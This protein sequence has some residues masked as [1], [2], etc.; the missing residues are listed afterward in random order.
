MLTLKKF[1]TLF[2]C[3]YHWLWTSKRQLGRCWKSF[4]IYT[5]VT[6][7]KPGQVRFQDFWAHTLA[8]IEKKLAVSLIH[9]LLQL[10][11]SWVWTINETYVFVIKFTVPCSLPTAQKLKFSIK[12]FFIFCA[13]YGA[14]FTPHFPFFIKMKIRNVS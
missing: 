11:L 12:D 9:I 3:F 14:C 1:R 7:T 2:W 4:Y 8:G 5:G 10:T 6:R 13:V